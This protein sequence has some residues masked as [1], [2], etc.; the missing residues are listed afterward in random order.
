[1]P[2]DLLLPW[3]EGIE[4]KVSLAAVIVLLFCR[5]FP[6]HSERRGMPFPRVLIRAR[7]KAASGVLTLLSSLTSF[8]SNDIDLM[9]G[10]SGNVEYVKELVVPAT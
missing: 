6:W 2:L 7:R 8:R 4:S 3:I 5:L 10:N 9:A 1:M